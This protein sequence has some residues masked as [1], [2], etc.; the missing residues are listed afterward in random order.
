VGSQF[1]VYIFFSTWTFILDYDNLHHWHYPSEIIMISYFFLCVICIN[2]PY[3]RKE[4]CWFYSSLSLQPIIFKI[5]G[6]WAESMSRHWW[7]PHWRRCTR[8]CWIVGHVNADTDMRIVGG[9]EGTPPEPIAGKWGT[10]MLR[11]ISFPNFLVLPTFTGLPQF[12]A[13]QKLK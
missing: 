7:S 9:T 5:G 12:E 13:A 2:I 6:L 10:I 8:L 1:C 11:T 3:L 4:L